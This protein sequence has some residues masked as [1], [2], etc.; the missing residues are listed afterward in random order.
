MKG[1]L[2]AWIIV[3]LASCTTPPTGPISLQV[4]GHGGMGRSHTHPINSLSSIQDLCQYKRTTGSAINGV[5]VDL[6]LTKD[7]MLV[8]YHDQYIRENGI[9][10]VVRALRLDQIEQQNASGHVLIPTLEQVVRDP[11][12]TDLV[13][14]LDVKLHLHQEEWQ[15]YLTDFAAALGNALETWSLE[16]RVIVE[17]QVPD[18]LKAVQ[19]RSP[20]V[21]TFYYVKTSE[22][23]DALITA[24]RD[25][26]PSVKINWQQNVAGITAH[27][28]LIEPAQISAAQQVG[29]AVA[30]FGCSGVRGNTRCVN[31]KPNFIETEDPDLLADWKNRARSS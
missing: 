10:Q 30:I 29:L 28:D 4:I 27:V 1:F 26:D 12:C 14:F 16:D 11:Q 17:C 24:K 23:I 22:E 25:V 13:Y 7:G 5:E 15:H 31:A 8:L 3:W 19:K 21:R 6:Q 20:M 9:D 2:W 18:L